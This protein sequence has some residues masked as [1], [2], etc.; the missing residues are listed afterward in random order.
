[1]IP[2]GREIFGPR[3]D[4]TPMKLLVENA[5]RALLV[6]ILAIAATGPLSW[7][8]VIYLFGDPDPSTSALASKPVLGPLIAFIAIPRMVFG[9][10]LVAVE[11]AAFFMMRGTLTRTVLAVAALTDLV[12]L[13]LYAL[14]VARMPHY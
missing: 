3:T 6:T 10:V 11:G 14:H 7:L 13:G 5:S 4:L 8:A 9:P 2:A 12:P 1:M